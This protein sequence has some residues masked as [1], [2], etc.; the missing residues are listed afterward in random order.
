MDSSLFLLVDWQVFAALLVLASNK[1]GDEVIA[2]LM[3][4]KPGSKP[5][6]GQKFVDHLTFISWDDSTKTAHFTF[7]IAP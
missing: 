7:Y 2:S 1:M 6:F 4:A 5:S 3:G